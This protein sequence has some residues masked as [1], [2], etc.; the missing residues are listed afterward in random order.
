LKI[1]LAA[2]GSS[3]A[4]SHGFKEVSKSFHNEIVA[5]SLGE[6]PVVVFLLM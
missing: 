4:G 3:Q 1:E 5:F 6:Q 2:L